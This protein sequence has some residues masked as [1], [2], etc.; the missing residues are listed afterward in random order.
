MKIAQTAL[1]DND[2]PDQMAEMPHCNTLGL[3]HGKLAATQ[4]DVDRGFL[5]T[6]SGQFTGLELFPYDRQP[7]NYGEAGGVLGRPQGWE[8]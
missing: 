7:I 5:N 2:R 1:A 6:R 8:R 3:A 4:S